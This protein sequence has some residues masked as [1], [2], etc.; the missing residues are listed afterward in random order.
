MKPPSV[1]RTVFPVMSAWCLAVCAL[2][3]SGP[4]EVP[5][6]TAPSARIDA[7]FA[8]YDRDDS[9][10][11]A[12]AIIR[13]GAIVYE[14]GYG[15]ADLEHNVP[16]T[17]ETVFYIGS[18]SKQ[19][20][21]M[22]MLLLDEYGRLSLDDDVRKYIPE[23]PYYGRTMTIRHLIHHTSGLRDYFTLW[24]LSGIDYANYNSE[25]ETLALI[26]R[27][28]GLNFMPGEERLYSNSGYL[29]LSV[30]VRRVTGLSLREFADERIF[31][32]LG[33]AQSRFLNDP[34]TIIP[35]RAYGHMKRAGDGGWD[36]IPFRF[37]L[38]G[39]G[40][41][42]TTVRDLALWDANFYDNRLGGGQALID[43]ML[44]PGTLHNGDTLTYAYALTVGE[45]RGLRTVRHG[46]ALGG[47]RS[48]ILRFPDER[49][50][51]IALFNLGNVNP[52]DYA[53]KVADI[54]L[55]DRLAPLSAETAPPFAATS[56]KIISVP[57]P[58]PSEYAGEFISGELMVR[59]RIVS[60][61]EGL[62]V[63]IRDTATHPMK[64]LDRDVFDAG[65]AT[66]RFTRDSRG[67]V[68]GFSVDAGRVVGLAFEK[69]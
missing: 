63:R 38:T 31:R 65:V 18:E 62:F 37:A 29:L 30:I 56:A 21:A 55:E 4:P 10:G 43:R 13:D 35:G 42:Y 2:T 22:C 32:P 40:G 1:F 11:C 46:G 27:Q 8:D 15:M 5:V 66:M 33:M 54:C 19:F 6:T 23:L 48:H 24:A 57:V 67:V 41:L 44:T 26:T 34:G 17:P 28:K 36:L 49:F 12:L 16:I 68:N 50:T 61:E 25:E 60:G 3:C 64:P 45:Y 20:A 58:R 53:E 14:R 69:I 39:S 7:V 47:Y 59:Y 9:P 52:G 51:V